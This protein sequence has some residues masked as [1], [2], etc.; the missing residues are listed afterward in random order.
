MAPEI[1]S[2][3]PTEVEQLQKLV[4]ELKEYSDGLFDEKETLKHRLQ[5]ML[6]HRFS[7]RSEKFSP[8]QKLLNF[9]GVKE[10]LAAA[11]LAPSDLTVNPEATD[12]DKQE[13]PEPQK[14]TGRKKLPVE[15]PR[16]EIIYDVADEDKSCDKCGED[17][18][19]IGEDT[20][21]Q[22]EYVPGYFKVIKNIQIKYGC[23]TR[24]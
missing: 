13:Q 12:E 16:E 3:L 19:R 7:S 5:Q 18:I 9:P 11:G 1:P 22:L 21:E 20:T 14:P 23:K 4:L 8:G 2:K 17:L 15:L 6:R 10:A 24:G